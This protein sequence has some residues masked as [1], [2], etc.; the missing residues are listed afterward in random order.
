MKLLIEKGANVNIKNTSGKTV[1]DFVFYSIANETKNTPAEYKN[2][3][4]EVQKIL[5]NAGAKRAEQLK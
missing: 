2:Y 5:E 1:L 3:Y 4:A